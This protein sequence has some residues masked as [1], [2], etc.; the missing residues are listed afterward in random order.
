MEKFD[1]S[2]YA[3]RNDLLCADGR[4]IRK[5][6]FRVND[7]ETVPL[8]Y[9][10]CHNDPDR[11]LGHALL[12]NRDD[13]VYAYC[14]FN[15][16]ESGL[17]AKEAVRHGDVKSLSIYANKLKQ[18]G[19]DVLHGVIREV[20]IVMAGA[21]PG[22]FIDSVMMHSD[23]TD[24]GVIVGYDENIMIHHY[25]EEEQPVQHAESEEEENPEMVETENERQEE[26]V[27]EAV[28]EHAEE[29]KTESKAE[30][31]SEEKSEAKP[32]TK[33]KTVKDIL[34]TLNEEQ[35]TAVYY[36]IGQVLEDAGVST[37]DDEKEKENENVK[38]SEGGNETMKTNVFDRE[39]EQ[40]DV[41]LSHA[42]QD[43]IL[44]NAKSVG[45]FKKAVEMWG[46]DHL[47]HGFGAEDGEPIDMLFTELKNVPAGAP[48]LLERDM[49]WVATVMAKANKSPIARVRTRQIDA[50]AAEI[51]AKAHKKGEQKKALANVKLLKRETHPQTVYVKDSL[52]RDDIN[53]IDFDAVSYM[54]NIMKHTLEE[55]VA[56]AAM[57]GDR[58]NEE[59]ADKISDQCIRP[60]WT[61]EELYAIHEVV[62]VAG[63]KTKL[64]G[65]NTGA[66][67]GD[68]FVR[69]EAIVA[70]LMNARIQYKGK[71]TADFYCDPALLNT[72]LLARDMNGRRIYDS[73]ADVA[74]VLNVGKIYTV[75]Q[76]AGLTREDEDGKERKLLGIFVNMNNYQFG[77]AKGG[78]VTSFQDFDIDYN[79]YKYLMETR[80]SGA[81]IDPY[82]AIVLEEVVESAAG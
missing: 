12:E 57:V 74:K 69:T 53:D 40:K 34:D 20:S 63:M 15:Q 39:T 41:I 10:H 25:T 48:A 55:T 19:N 21:N 45:S 31:K 38:H 2:G 58:R 44:D 6:A 71:G 26:V 47:Q 18:S 3:T 36:V 49:D 23:D 64:Q 27:E 7:G 51:T 80:L 72:M 52:H 37:E 78:E 70:A 16:S 62:D 73:A 1:F 56:L 22:A 24:E 17:A 14:T 8:L 33:E 42:D 46:K 29:P 79:Q 61:D 28:I 11:I 5:D 76:F 4:I 13:G 68:E 9:G 50:R 60:I 66:N 75:E 82:S 65:S 32:E 30:A 59:E 77:C 35:M 43:Q 67:F 81:L 54:R